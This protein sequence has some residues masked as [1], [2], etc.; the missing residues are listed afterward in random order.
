M[1][2]IQKF[3][4]ELPNFSNLSPKFKLVEIGRASCRKSVVVRVVLG[5]RRVT[6]KKTEK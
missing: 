1:L 4:I 6:N 3:K 2:L 5:G